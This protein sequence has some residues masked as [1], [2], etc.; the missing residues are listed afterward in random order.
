MTKDDAV[1]LRKKLGLT[2]QE[3]AAEL[4][5]TGRSWQDVESGKTRLKKLHRLA[6]EMIA[7]ERAEAVG[8]LNMATARVRRIALGLARQ[9][10]G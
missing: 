2:Q 8:D 3:L 4:G 10:T 9:I 6:L 1:A 7:L 5:I